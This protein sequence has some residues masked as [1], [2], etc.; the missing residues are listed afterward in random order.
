MY[1]IIVNNL[2]SIQIV[3]ARGPL[4]S[5]RGKEET[6]EKKTP[7]ADLLRNVPVPLQVASYQRKVRKIKSNAEDSE[8]SASDWEYDQ[9]VERAVE[10]REKYRNR[11]PRKRNTSST[12]K[13]EKV[14]C[15][16]CKGCF[17]DIVMRNHFNSVH[18]VALNGKYIQ[19]NQCYLAF[20][21]LRNLEIHI[22]ITHAAESLFR[23]D[24]CVRL[25]DNQKAVTKHK[26]RI[27]RLRSCEICSASCCDLA[28]LKH[29]L[30]ISI[31]KFSIH[32]N[33]NVKKK[34]GK[35]N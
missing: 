18:S 29:T 8:E 26:G 12:S 14:K 13:Q 4:R 33:R 3:T 28:T 5:T 22:E 16:G 20:E 25:F 1:I 19:C 15:P 27:D 32:K 7:V 9:A 23:C 10:R 30:N 35:K 21:D 24:K 34:Y 17:S 6:V 2:C 31:Q 11:P